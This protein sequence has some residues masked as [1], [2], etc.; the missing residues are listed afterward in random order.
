MII[1]FRSCHRGLLCAVLLDQVDSKIKVEM[2]IVI[3]QF[4][5]ALFPRQCQCTECT[6]S[7]FNY[8][9]QEDF[10]MMRLYIRRDVMAQCK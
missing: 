10:Y 4:H 8:E 2:H 3:K 5:A 7:V 6:K 1:Y 9:N